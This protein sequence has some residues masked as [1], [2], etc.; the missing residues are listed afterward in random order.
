MTAPRL[1]WTAFALF[2]ASVPFANWLIGHVGT[3]CVPGGPCLVPVAPGL[4]APSGVLAAGAALVLRDAVQRCLG[5]RAALAAIVA[6]TLLSALV[7]PGKS[8]SAWLH[9]PQVLGPDGA[10]VPVRGRVL[11]HDGVSMMMAGGTWGHVDFEDC[12][13]GP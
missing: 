3:T 6:G 2:L 10:R 1:G 8:V 13:R 5:A 12:P 11:W 4:L 9:P 7:A